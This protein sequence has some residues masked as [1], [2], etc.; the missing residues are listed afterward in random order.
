MSAAREVP[1]ERVLVASDTQEALLRG[2][3]RA[4]RIQQMTGASVTAVLVL[5]DPVTEILI[6]R[7]SADVSQRVIDDL[8]RH[9]R[10][11]LEAAIAPLRASMTQLDVE[12][13]FA[14]QAASA[15]CA[16]ARDHHASLIVKPLAASAHLADFLH[17]PVDW[18]LMREAPCPVL[19]T[20]AQPWPTPA[21]VLATI[22]V[23]DAAHDQLNLDILRMGAE[24]AATVGAEFHV[25]TVIPALAPYVRVYEVVPDYSSTQAQLRATRR[26]ALEA[27]LKAGGAEATALHVVDGRPADVIRA[28]AAE[29]S[30]GLTV[31]G[32]AART[33]LK[34]LLIGNTAESIIRDLSTDL[35]TIRARKPSKAKRK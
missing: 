22:D 2:M 6:E 35:L 7:Y 3:E 21:R 16:A 26:A 15:F 5:Y 20:R 31:V 9:E 25:A 8:V 11:E 10:E 30:V 27:L 4:A 23:S 1:I 34:K 29:L 12:V 17:A 32:T 24:V 19:F 14:R 18:Q 28:L 13:V 33:G